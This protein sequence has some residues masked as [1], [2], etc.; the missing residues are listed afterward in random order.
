MTVNEIVTTLLD[1]GFATA[2]ET[3]EQHVRIPTMR[4]PVF[5]GMGGERRTLG[6]RA[7]YALPG[8]DL[9]VTVG[10]RTT[11]VY[12]SRGGGKIEF[13]LNTHTKQL[14][15]QEIRDAVA[16]ARGRKTT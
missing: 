10:P 14:T 15:A 6:G 1:L 2:G 11:N 12:F 9:R 8:T 4:S 5:G 13:V 7:R 3:A 16:A